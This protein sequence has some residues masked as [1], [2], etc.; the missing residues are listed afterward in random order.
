PDL[1][2]VIFL[3]NPTTTGTAGTLDGLETMRIL[4]A[5][6]GMES[7]FG[8]GDFFTAG[9]NPTERLHVLDGRV[10]IEQLPDDPEAE[11]LTKFLVVD[12]VDPGSGEYGV[13]KWRHLPTGTGGSCEWELL[14]GNRVATAWRNVGTNGAWPEKRWVVDVGT[15]VPE[16]KFQIQHSEQDRPV[17]GGLRVNLTTND[18][19]WN[20]GIKSY[21]TPLVGGLDLYNGHAVFG[22]IRDA[23]KSSPLAER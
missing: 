4:P 9:L 19:G 16:A 8:I 14:G 11:E 2:K 3:A 12:D 5:T 1:F 17:N 23:G 6:T 18:H 10:R 7:Y 22:E 20:Y 15:Q 13:V 21:I